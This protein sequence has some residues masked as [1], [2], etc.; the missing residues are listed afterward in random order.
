METAESSLVGNNDESLTTSTFI[1]FVC[2]HDNPS[3]CRCSPPHYIHIYYYFYWH[4]QHIY[5]RCDIRTKHRT[6]SLHQEMKIEKKR[7]KKETIETHAQHKLSCVSIWKIGN[8]IVVCLFGEKRKS[9]TSHTRQQHKVKKNP[10]FSNCSRRYVCELF[11]CRS[12]VFCICYE[13]FF[14]PLQERQNNKWAFNL[15]FILKQQK[16]CCAHTN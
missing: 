9:R 2:S 8:F 14:G 15:N 5:I 10:L 16:Q 4:T 7:K 3:I 12:I 13:T 11:F 1:C 6:F